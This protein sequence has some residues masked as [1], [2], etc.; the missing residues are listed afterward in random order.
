MVSRERGTKTD[1]AAK[2]RRAASIAAHELHDLP[3]APASRTITSMDDLRR[4]DQDFKRKRK[5][6]LQRTASDL[7]VV[8]PFPADMVSAAVAGSSASGSRGGRPSRGSAAEG[9]SVTGEA[10]MISPRDPTDHDA[11]GLTPRARPIPLGRSSG[12]GRRHRRTRTGTDYSLNRSLPRRGTHSGIAAISDSAG[13]PGTSDAFRG[14]I[15]SSV[16]AE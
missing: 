5:A 1:V 7:I 12:K 14:S 16:E 6:K 10:K 2:R 4:A 13:S 9:M 8:M 11:D 3:V 15:V